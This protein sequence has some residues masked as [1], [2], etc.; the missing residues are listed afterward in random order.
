MLSRAGLLTLAGVLSLAAQAQAVIVLGP[1]QSVPISQILA[2]QDKK[3]NIGDKQFTFLSFT[4]SSSIIGAT[5]LVAFVSPNN[6]LDGIG[7][8]L[9]GPF[10]DTNSGDGLATDLIFRYTV[11][12]LP[13]Y[14]AQ[15]L[16]IVDNT[17]AF[18]GAASGVGSYARVDETILGPNGIDVIAQTSVFANSGPPAAQKLSDR[19]QATPPT[20]YLK[21]EVVKDIQFK[22][23]PGGGTAT[24]SFIRQ[25]FSQIPSPG[26]A[27]LFGIAALAAARRRR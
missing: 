16:R 6:P 22:A 12:V 27:G 10:S 3:V 14:A 15:G 8:D 2:S 5:D 9:Q 26:A 13:T 18:N 24:A 1:N 19:W 25:A 4:G 11:E 20:N 7:F 23:E 21:L 17:L